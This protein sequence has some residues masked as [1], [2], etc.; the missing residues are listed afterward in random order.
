MS[1]ILIVGRSPTSEE[2]K[3]YFLHCQDWWWEIL[4]VIK[5]LFKDRLPVKTYFVRESLLAA[6][7]PRMDADVSSTFSE[8]LENAL[9]DGS[10]DAC[11]R[12]IYKE[13]STLYEYYGE[14]E[15]LIND[16]LDERIV[17]LTKFAKFLKSCGGCDV[18][19]YYPDDEDW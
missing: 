12:K 3:E 17:Q 1:D 6:P 15:E 4:F 18:K 11:L 7:A 8:L 14:D 9:A 19:W 16:S 10:V 13:N 2:G 5:D